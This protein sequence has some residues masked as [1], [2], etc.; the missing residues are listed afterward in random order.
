M[1]QL[2][3]H[4]S[5]F[6]GFI[7][8]LLFGIS[9]LTFP[10]IAKAQKD[11]ISNRMRIAIFSPM[12]LDSAFDASGSYRHGKS[13]PKYLAAGLEFYQGIQLAVDSLQNE[14]APVD[15]YIYDTRSTRKKLESILAGE[16]IKTMDLFLG[17][18]NMNDATQL[19]R[20]AT[21]LEIPF[22]NINL[23]NDAGVKGNPHYII[24]N[25]TLGT[26][27]AAI[28]KFL[29]KNYAL[30]P[31]YYFRKKTAAEDQLR[32][33]FTDADKN[34]ASVPLKIKYITLEDTVTTDQ[35][36]KFLDSTKTNVC[37]AGS[38]D[39]NFSLALARQLASLS[40]SY[41]SVVIGMPTWDKVD[42]NKAAYRGIEIIYSN[43]LYINNDNRLVQHLNNLYKLKY[44]SR[45]GDLVF[46]GFETLYHFSHLLSDTTASFTNLLATKKNSLFGEIDIQPVSNKQT[47]EPDYYENK[48]LYFIKRADGV[49][50]GVY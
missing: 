40:K 15:I 28:Y 36:K 5:Y 4:N 19:A 14:K 46:S 37:V 2:R 48:K 22:V 45:P 17:Y 30:S 16:E 13:L 27:C 39:A 1:D 25:P 18:V 49:I 31:I 32:K 29:Q 11:T 6:T 3:K 50:K 8:A 38:M 20:S 10:A 33:Y 43:S 7:I 24:L 34:T 21:A 47:G 26:H 44:F 41:R 23:P 12:Y 35:L 9:L 42:F